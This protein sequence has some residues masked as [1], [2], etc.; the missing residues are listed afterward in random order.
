MTNDAQFQA[1][2]AVG[3]Q[4]EDEKPQDQ[5]RCSTKEELETGI[6][7]NNAETTHAIS[8]TTTAPDLTDTNQDRNILYEREKKVW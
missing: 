2:P 7:N 4:T 1:P 3:Q 5:E 6:D 8:P